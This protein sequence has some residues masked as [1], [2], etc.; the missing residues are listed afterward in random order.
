MPKAQIPYRR[1]VALVSKG[2]CTALTK[3]VSMN[4]RKYYTIKQTIRGESYRK[5]DEPIDRVA[6][7]AIFDNPFI[8]EFVEDLSSLF[9]LGEEIAMLLSDD[10]DSIT[11][12]DPTS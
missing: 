6:A 8:G 12:G 4:V 9:E 3:R 7:M 5:T 2:S 10:A 11:Y 1:V